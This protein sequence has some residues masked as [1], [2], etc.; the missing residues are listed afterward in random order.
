MKQEEFNHKIERFTAQAAHEEALAKMLMANAA[1]KFEMV[2]AMKQMKE[3]IETLREQQKTMKVEIG[4]LNGNFFENIQ[5]ANICQ[6][7]SISSTEHISNTSTPTSNT[8][9]IRLSSK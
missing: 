7:S 6:P 9:I 8:N 5:N 3:E 2:E 1:E 4:T